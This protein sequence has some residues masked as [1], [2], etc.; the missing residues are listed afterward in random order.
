[1]LM[2]LLLPP[3]PPPPPLDVIVPH[4]NRLPSFTFFVLN[5]NP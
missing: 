2:L 3:P 5:L 4:F 1:M